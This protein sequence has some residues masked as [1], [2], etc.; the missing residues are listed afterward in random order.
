MDKK[1][2]KREIEDLS[3]KIRQWNYEYYVLNESSISDSVYDQYYQK[4]ILLEQ[5]YPHLIK[6]NSPSKTVG[7]NIA[8]S[9]FQKIKHQQSMLS[10]SNAFNENDLLRFDQQVKKITGLNEV[11]YVCELKIDG[12]SISIIYNEGK[13]QLAATRGDGIYGEDISENVKAISSVP[14]T[15]NNHNQKIEVRGEVYLSKQDFQNLNN[16]QITQKQMVFANPRNAASGTLRQLD[17]NIVKKRNLNAFLYYYV[18]AINDGINFH[19]DALKYIEK[20]NFNVNKEWRLCKNINEVKQYIKEYKFKRNSLD[21][22]IDGIVIKVNNLN[23]YD[24]LGNT[25]KAPRWAIA[26]KFPAVTVT[27]KLLKIFPTV[28]RTGKIT[29][30]AQLKPVLLSGS[31]ISFAT[32]H[33]GDYIIEKD[34]QINDI[35]EI[36]KAGDVIPEVIKPILN[37]RE[38]TK[39]FILSTN[40][41]VCNS[42]LQ[43]FEGE[44][45]QYCVNSNCN[46]RILKSLIHFCSRDAM[47]ITGLSDKTLE[48]FIN[49][50][51][52]NNL[53]DI[54]NLLNLRTEILSLE[55]FGEKSF[56]NL[57]NNIIL[58]KNNSLEKFLF[59]LGIRHVG[60]KTAE[61]LAQKYQDLDILINTSFEDLAN[62]RDIGPTISKS[63]V[64]YFSNEKNKELINNFK[65]LNINFKYINQ[66]SNEQ[67]FANQTFVI[68]GTLS[69]SR[70]YFAELLK[71]YGA[72]ITN[73]ISKNTDYLLAGENSGS[74]LQKATELNIKIITEEELNNLIIS[75]TS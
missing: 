42:K 52:I 63:I 38:N 68:T 20:L 58:S 45:D 35:V 41:P 16:S 59:G 26:Y 15:I 54:Y 27:T 56:N 34:L 24:V 64:D 8:N 25:N 50:K 17:F 2:I 13:L 67:I 57:A 7:S 72:T 30:N 18:N 19:S 32:L 5:K 4:L 1:E 65:K 44:V 48:K 23:L 11:E 43:K 74:K 73:S 3:E 9:K 49:L 40:C 33:N 14:L 69:K 53:S 51:W 61:V 12:L 6:A 75:K 71:K 62:N 10:L 36:K 60:K 47:D 70:T 37:L 66:E 22:E 21:Y 29:Y 28:G 31:T 39:K 46:A 55:K